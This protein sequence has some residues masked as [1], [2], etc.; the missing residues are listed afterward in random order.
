MTAGRLKDIDQQIAS[1][2][3]RYNRTPPR[4]R[5]KRRR[6]R[7]AV[8]GRLAGD[9]GE[10]RAAGEQLAKES[11]PLDDE[12]KSLRKSHDDRLASAQSQLA[13]APDQGQHARRRRRHQ[14]ESMYQR[15]RRAAK[16]MGRLRE[17]I[18]ATDV[19][20][21]ASLRVRLMR[22]WTTSSNGSIL[23]IVL[24]FDPLAVALT[25]GF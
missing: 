3:E 22:R 5:K 10:D 14:V 21:Y 18:A 23:V 16:E 9:R 12:E 6:Q 2:H 15:L 8:T 4:W 19:G 7:K 20:S 17:Q 13:G 1:A 25:I 11:T 24:V